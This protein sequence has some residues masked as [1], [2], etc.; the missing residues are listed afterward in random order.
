MAVTKFKIGIIGVGMVGMPLKRYFE[1]VKKYQRGKELFLYD[2]DPKKGY[3]DDINKADVVFVCVPTPRLTNGSADLKVLESAFDRIGQRKIVVIKSTVPPGTTETLQKKYSQHKVLFNPE[4]LTEVNA[5]NNTV[6]PDRQLVG[7]TVSSREVAGDVLGLLP[8]AP[9]SAPSLELEL[10]ATEAEII[11]YAANIFLTRKVVFA[12][13]IFDLAKHHGVD[14]ERIKIGVS[15]DPRIGSSHLDVRHG[16]YRGYGGYCFI[17]DMDALIAH[18][19][20]VGLKRVAD[21][22]ASDRAFN[23]KILQEQGLSPEDVAIHDHEWIQRKLES[24]NPK[25]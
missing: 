2:I 15:S 12:N 17:K 3:F 24:L 9:L 8:A 18:C 25:P 11:K 4:F 19:A 20:E 14:Y 7:W 1:E 10:T 5:W 23:N 21:L 16:G 22:F 6:S 13:A